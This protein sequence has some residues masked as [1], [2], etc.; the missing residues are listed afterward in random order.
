MNNIISSQV[1]RAWIYRV[2]IAAQPLVVLYGVASSEQIALWL[3]VVSAAL[4]FGLAA[5]NTSTVK[6]VGD[7]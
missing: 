4:G 1:I 3:G 6:D 5:A 2:L 7:Q